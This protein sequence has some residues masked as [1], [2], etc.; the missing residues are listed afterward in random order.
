MPPED[1][2]IDVAFIASPQENPSTSDNL[3]LITI[4]LILGITQLLILLIVRKKLKF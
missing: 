3:L 2:T 1:I 4:I